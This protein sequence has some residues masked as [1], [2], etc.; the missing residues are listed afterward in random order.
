VF[1]LG[2]RNLLVLATQCKVKQRTIERPLV[3]WW[4]PCV[5]H[6]VTLIYFVGMNFHETTSLLTLWIS[7]GW[8]RKTRLG[9]RSLFCRRLLV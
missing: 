1:R 6:H 2:L 3:A 4:L 7:N 9:D 5:V 8:S